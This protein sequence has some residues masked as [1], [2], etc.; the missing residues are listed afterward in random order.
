MVRRNFTRDVRAQIVKRAMNAAGQ[1]C[2][3]VCGL[4][5]GKKPYQ[6]DHTKPDGLEVDKSRRLT[7]DDGKLLGQECCHGPKTTQVDRPMIDRAKRREAKHLG[8]KTPPSQTIPSRG[9]ASPFAS[10]EQRA[11]VQSR[12]LAEADLD[13]TPEWVTD[14]HGMRVNGGRI[15]PLEVE[16][17]SLKISVAA[18]TAERDAALARLERAEKALANARPLVSYGRI[19]G[20]KSISA[21]AKTVLDEID[22]FFASKKGNDNG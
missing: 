10:N 8:T 3:E 5:L 14:E 15:Y 4:V 6:I 19:H 1:V 18:M 20:Y 16:V 12:V 21:S 13:E 9:F 11:A 17:L 22:A 7:A 2:C